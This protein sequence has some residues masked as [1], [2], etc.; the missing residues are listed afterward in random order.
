M[1]L[2][3]KFYRIPKQRRNSACRTSYILWRHNCLVGEIMGNWQCEY[4]GKNFHSDE[5]QVTGSCYCPKC[6]ARFDKITAEDDKRSKDRKE[7]RESKEYK[8]SQEKEGEERKKH[9]S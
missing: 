1:G 9:Q 8:D 2:E 6:K 4:C 5:Q 7:Y 3:V